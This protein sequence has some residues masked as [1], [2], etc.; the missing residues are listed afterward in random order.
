MPIAKIDD[1]IELN[2]H[3]AEFLSVVERSCWA[4][5]RA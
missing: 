4:G 2:L 5:W 3:I 1:A